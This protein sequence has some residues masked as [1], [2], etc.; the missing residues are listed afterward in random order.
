MQ[1]QTVCSWNCSLFFPTT[2]WLVAGHMDS[3]YQTALSTLCLCVCLCMCDTYAMFE[4]MPPWHCRYVISDKRSEWS[5]C[6]C[7]FPPNWRL[8]GKLKEVLVTWLLVI[9]LL[10]VFEILLCSM[11]LC[12]HFIFKLL[13]VSMWNA[14]LKYFST[15]YLLI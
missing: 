15:I 3:V 2:W 11:N 7:C 8:L 9:W 13:N 10:I 1:M 14:N 5:F 12:I 6:Y 4:R